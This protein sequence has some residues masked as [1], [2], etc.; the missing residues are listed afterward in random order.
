V[1]AITD[2]LGLIPGNTLVL[3]AGSRQ[4]IGTSRKP[5]MLNVMQ[6]FCP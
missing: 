2:W 4:M 1:P 5:V 3:R 6:A